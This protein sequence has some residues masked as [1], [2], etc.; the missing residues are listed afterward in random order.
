ML[1]VVERFYRR[2]GSLPPELWNPPRQA[3]FPNP[4]QQTCRELSWV[5][6]LTLLRNAFCRTEPSDSA[7]AVLL[8]AVSRAPGMHAECV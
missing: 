3:G 1:E 2:G 7:L 6:L 8:T 4:E 5:H